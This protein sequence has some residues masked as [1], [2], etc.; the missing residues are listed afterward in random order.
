MEMKITCCNHVYAHGQSCLTLAM[1]AHQ[2]PLFMGFSWQEYSS[3]HFLLQGIFPTQGSNTHL[4]WLLH[5]RQV[6]L[7]LRQLGSPKLHLQL[8]LGAQFM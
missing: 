7:P 6:I 1:V 5:C 3:C 4:Q 8:N 2:A